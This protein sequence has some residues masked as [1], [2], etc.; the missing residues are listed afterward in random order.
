LSKCS[1][2][3]CNREINKYSLVYTDF[4]LVFEICYE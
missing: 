1:R 3:I 2:V 4:G